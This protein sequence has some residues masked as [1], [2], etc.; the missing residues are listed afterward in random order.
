M[1]KTKKPRIAELDVLKGATILTVVLCHSGA[2]RH[3]DMNQFPVYVMLTEWIKS[4][5]MQT[6]FMVSGL[7]FAKA[8]PKPFGEFFKSKWERLAVPYL[9][10]SFITLFV[11]CMVP[12]LFHRPSDPILL[13][14]YSIL[15]YGKW[16][17]FIYTLFVLYMVFFFFKERLTVLSACLVILVMM[18]VKVFPT[19]HIGFLK[20]HQASYFGGFFLMGFIMNTYYPKIREWMCKWWFIPVNLVIFALGFRY[21]FNES[22]VNHWAEPDGYSQSLCGRFVYYW[23][24]PVTL[25]LAFWSMCIFL[26]KNKTATETMKYCGEYSLQFYLF[27]G[28]AIGISREILMRVLHTNNPYLLI[29]CLFSTVCIVTILMVEITRRL[30]KLS[31]YFGYGKSSKT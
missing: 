6:F 20:I 15:C 10:L 23:I 12:W 28:F 3:I 19:P 17:W 7:L 18:V 11:K 5:N 24:L 26:T 29:A 16:Y 14:I 22:F 2:Y 21:C 8:K 9:V 4:W 27:N 25:S 13:S 1:N 31:Y 30:P